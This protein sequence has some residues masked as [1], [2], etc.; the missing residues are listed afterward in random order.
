[1]LNSPILVDDRV[2]SCDLIKFF[3]ADGVLTRLDSADLAFSGNGPA[4][5]S[6]MIGVERKRVQDLL[7][8]MVSG[9]LLNVQ[10]PDLLANYDY[11]YL[12]VEGL[13]KA[14]ST[15][16]LKV[17]TSGKWADPKLG[18]RN[19][20]Y[21]DVVKFLATLEMYGIRIRYTKTPRETASCVRALRDW[22]AKDWDSHGLSVVPAEADVLGL[23]RPNLVQRVASQLPGVGAK[24]ARSVSKRFSTVS[25][26][27]NAS[28]SE[29]TGIEKIGSKK[30]EII[31]KS[32]RGE[33]K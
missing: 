11:Q 29:W 2:G 19:V 23:T 4:A 33:I 22:W 30:A 17:M 12:I 9:R 6:I 15:G 21:D 24:L 31:T 1:M 7:G 20:K 32:L 18:N 5:A 26:M 25:E 27:V 3:P 14:S 10:I 8:S 28:K 13:Y 16:D